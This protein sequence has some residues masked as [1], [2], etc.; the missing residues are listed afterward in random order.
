MLPKPPSL[1]EIH[2]IIGTMIK[3]NVSYHRENL[4]YNITL[5]FCKFSVPY[6][7]HFL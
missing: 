7:I 3:K 5:E 2:S 4:K 1:S 6:I